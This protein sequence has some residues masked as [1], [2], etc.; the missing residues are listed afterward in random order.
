MKRIKMNLGEKVVISRGDERIVVEF[1]GVK[2][3]RKASLG[4]DAKLDWRVELCDA[5]GTSLEKSRD[6]V[7]IH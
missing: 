2:S 1:V 7:L 5:A 6:D 4:V 3:G